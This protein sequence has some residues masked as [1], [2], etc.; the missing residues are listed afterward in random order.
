MD[1]EGRLVTN[2]KSADDPVAQTMFMRECKIERFRS[3]RET[4]IRFQPTVTLLVGENNAGKSNVIEAL[5]LATSPL[6]GRRTR[7]FE[8]E[9]QTRLCS[10]PVNIETRFEGLSRFQKAQYISAFDLTTDQAVYMTKFTPPDDVN[11]RGRVEYLAGPGPSPDPEP[12]NRDRVKHVYLAPL[13]DAQRELDSASGSRLALIMRHLVESEDRDDFV[14]QAQEG[15]TRLAQHNAVTTVS[16]RIQGHLKE[17]T[18]TSRRQRVEMGFEP[19]ELHRLARGLRLKMADAH[20]DPADLAV[21]GLGYANLLFLATVIL[22]LQNARESELTLFLVEE[23]EAHLHPQLQ[24]VLLDFLAEQAE[25]SAHEDGD[26]PAGRIQVIATTHSPNLASAV[27]T[28]NVVVLRSVQESVVVGSEGTHE[29]I[30]QTVAIPLAELELDADER[31]K[32]DQYLDVTRSE[33]LFTRRA[34]L[35]EGIA[36]A[37]LLPVLA[38]HCSLS[39]DGDEQR[40]KRRWFRG[41]SIISVG[42]VDFRPYLKLLLGE[43][44][45]YRLVD[46][47][48][49]IT[50]HDPPVPKKPS[51]EGDEQGDDEEEAEKVYNRAEDLR[52]LADALGATECL[53][54]A[55][56]PHTLEADLLVPGAINDGVL[57][58]AFLAQRPRS[59]TKWTGIVGSESPAAAF[60]KHLR[61]N[62]KLISKGQFAHDVAKSI[63]GGETFVCPDYLTEAIT[64]VVDRSPSD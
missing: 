40:R 12:E 15:F 33:L 2:T 54:I 36:E 1:N 58:K 64:A 49:V 53:D 62:S 4:T 27:G 30:D 60:H 34:I 21:S 10:A 29:K 24:A 41:T 19:P 23:P 31:R 14:L 57:E 11:L 52:A 22:E 51:G 17:L 8:P 20:L 59:K 42:S 45:G 39:G 48:V 63:A 3:C 9:D 35:V 43:V 37:V 32:I 61:W 44:D 13:R 28:E 46:H 18:D 50:D 26:G 5:R 6:S 56:A 38:S 25:E 55:E 7:Y 16:G 47:L